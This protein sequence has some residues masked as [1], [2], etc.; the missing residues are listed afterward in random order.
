MS[1]S[2]DLLGYARIR[3]FT[4]NGAGGAMRTPPTRRQGVLHRIGGLDFMVESSSIR[5]LIGDTGIG[6]SAAQQEQLFQPF[7]RLGREGSFIEGTGIGLM[8]T[9]QLV[10][11]MGGGVLRLDSVEGVGTEAWVTLPGLG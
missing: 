7:N 4:G 11:L 8:L 3:L 6:M 2:M 9:R 5:I 10:E 1:R